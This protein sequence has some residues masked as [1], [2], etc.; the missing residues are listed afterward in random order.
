MS[1]PGCGCCAGS[2]PAPPLQAPSAP[3]LLRGPRPGPRGK[4]GGSRGLCRPRLHPGVVG[5]RPQT[6]C[7]PL[8]CSDIS[9]E[10]LNL[11]ADALDSSP[12]KSLAGPASS[13]SSLVSL[14]HFPLSLAWAA[15]GGL[16][17]HS[18]PR[19]LRELPWS[20]TTFLPGSGPTSLSWI[21]SWAQEPSLLGPHSCSATS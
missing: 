14:P 17:L 4:Q 11:A 18:R 8:C 1:P 6:H 16:L 10:K 2:S 3:G 9:L 19:D 12:Q 20:H 5:P 21:K 15:S 13:P 7:H